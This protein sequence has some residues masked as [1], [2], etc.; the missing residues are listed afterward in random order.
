MLVE[1]VWRM[2][3]WQLGYTA[4]QKWARVLNSPTRTVILDETGPLKIAA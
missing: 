2:M 4:L 3:R 1:M